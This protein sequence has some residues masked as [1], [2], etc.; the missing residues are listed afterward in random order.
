EASAAGE[1]SG[2]ERRQPDVLGSPQADLVLGP[3]LADVA[4]S[5]RRTRSSPAGEGILVMAGR[6][7]RL[8]KNSSQGKLL[9]PASVFL[10]L[11][12]VTVY[13]HLGGKRSIKLPGQAPAVAKA[14]PRPQQ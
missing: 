14:E 12:G 3:E 9:Q 11:V 2:R 7:M 6:D 1:S 10:L 13:V 4:A 8:L 5:H